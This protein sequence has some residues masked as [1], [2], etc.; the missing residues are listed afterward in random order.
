MPRYSRECHFHCKLN[1]ESVKAHEGKGCLGEG[2]SHTLFLYFTVWHVLLTS[3]KQRK[4]MNGKAEV[5]LHWSRR[6]ALWCTCRAC[7]PASTTVSKNCTIRQCSAVGHLSLRASRSRGREEM[8]G[9]KAKQ[10]RK[11]IS[12]E[13]QMLKMP[14]ASRTKP[15][16]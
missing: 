13:S 9:H 15:S 14:T 3:G 2:E 10:E 1:S 7:G 4:S 12:Y 6:S 5:I 8:R 11:P 16:S